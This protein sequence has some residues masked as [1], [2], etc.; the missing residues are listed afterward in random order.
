M[1]KG[2]LERNGEREIW[3]LGEKEREKR[4]KITVRRI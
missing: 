4:R 3:R 2:D 1:R